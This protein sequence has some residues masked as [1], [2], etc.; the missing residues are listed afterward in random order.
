MFVNSDKFKAFVIDKRRTNYTNE[1]IQISNEDI[2]IVPSVKLLRIT[3][4]DHLN[5]NEHM[6][7]ICKST[8]NHLNVLKT[9]L[10]SDERK[11]LVNSFVLSNFNYC[12]LVWFVSTSTSLRRIEILHKR[13]LRFLLNDYVSSCEQLLQKSSKAS[14][15][16]RNHRVLWNDIFKTII[17]LNPSDIKEIFER[18]VSNKRPVRNNYK[19]NLVTRKTNQ[20][21]HGTKS[22][23]SLA[24]EMWN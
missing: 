9:F 7:R 10:G 20:V 21:R 8:A 19:M 3:I 24:P 14:I 12:P 6:S 22:L 23:R 11:V 2:Q 16:L 15:N 13:A 1:K 4:D 17:D 5:F 18:S